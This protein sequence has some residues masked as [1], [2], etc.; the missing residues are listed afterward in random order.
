M[1]RG[2]QPCGKNSPWAATPI[3]ASLS[4]LGLLAAAVFSVPCSAEDRTGPSAIRQGLSDDLDRSPVDLVLAADESWLVTANQTSHSVSLVH[5]AE[6]RVLDECL[7]GRRPVALARHPDGRRV[8]VTCSDSGELVLLEV[9]QDQ[10][11]RQESIAV[12]TAPQG[13]AIDAQ[14]AL[15]YVALAASDQV[16]VVDLQARQVCARIDVGRWPRYLA[17]SP[18][19]RRLAVGTSGDRGLSVVD[20]QQ[21]QL[22]YVERFSGL[23]IGQ[24]ACSSDGQYAY[25]PWIVYRRN[26]ITAGNIRLGWVLASRIGRVRLD[27]PARRE[28]I[29]LDPQGEAVADPHGLALSHD[30]RR[31]VVTA[32]GTHELLVFRTAGL[33]FADHGGTDHIDRAL[34]AD[35]ERFFRVPLGGRPMAVRLSPDD[36]LA[37]VANYL[38]NSI[39]VVDLEQRRIT[40]Q[41]QLGSAAELSLARRG[42]AIF[43]DGRRSLDQWYSCHS[44]HYEG[45]T[46]AE[47]MDTLNDGSA[48]TF[49]TVL[50]LYHLDQTSPWTWHGWQADLR[51]VLSKSLTTTMLGPEPSAEDLDALLAYLKTLPPPPSPNRQADGSLGAAALRGQAVFR[52]ERAGCATCH[53]GP[54]FTDGQIHDVG[55]GGKSDRYQGYNTPSL[56]GVYRKTHL[57]HDGRC[58]SFEE[59][60]TGP[61]QP[62][63][64]AGT[65]E[66]SPEEQAD[67]MEYLRSL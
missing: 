62:T 22:S 64:V 23:N 36:R 11:K 8:A 25:F 44:C 10:L 41:I 46:N 55:T 26:P 6:G 47:L 1:Y 21:R 12:G 40:R 2:N 30:G 45:G 65:G 58:K 66:L 52:S 34:L 60:L 13:I 20:T 63:R 5:P 3:A 4:I 17:L 43:Y 35:K 59:L 24:L 7:V 37:Y 48:L 51:E 53:T 33:P 32:S 49:K 29:S 19:G 16:A 54:Y 38:E 15:A 9:A 57:M 56:L 18:D 42:E 28:A 31:L 27:G 50:P 67:L 39:Q 61:H 14:G